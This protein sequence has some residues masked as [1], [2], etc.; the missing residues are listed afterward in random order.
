MYTLHCRFDSIHE[1]PTCLIAV[2]LNSKNLPT[3]IQTNNVIFR[4]TMGSLM[5]TYSNSFHGS[6]CEQYKSICSKFRMLCLESTPNPIFYLHCMGYSGLFSW[7]SAVIQNSFRALYRF[8]LTFPACIHTRQLHNEKGIL[9]WQ[10]YIE[11][12]I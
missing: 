8:C 4:H 2:P 3:P 5:Y 11:Q 10:F 7:R 1:S 12:Y 9:G 6:K